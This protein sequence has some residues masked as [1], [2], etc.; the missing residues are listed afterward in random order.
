MQIDQSQLFAEPRP[1]AAQIRPDGA[2]AVSG[3]A[4]QRHRA[5]MTGMIMDVLPPGLWES[6][7]FNRE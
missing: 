1:S 4:T 6:M 5:T 2:N 3:V 7:G